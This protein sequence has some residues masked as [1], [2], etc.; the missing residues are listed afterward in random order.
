MMEKKGPHYSTCSGMLDHDLPC[1]CG[2]VAIHRLVLDAGRASL[3]V[4]EAPAPSPASSDLDGVKDAFVDETMIAYN[5]GKMG[6][7]SAIRKAIDFGLSLYAP[8]P[9]SVGCEKHEWYQPRDGWRCIHCGSPY[10]SAPQEAT[11]E[12]EK[13]PHG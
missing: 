7:P 1:D 5:E 3:A 4:V 9:P 13:D 10:P 8:T 12:K 2:Y 6:F 11:T